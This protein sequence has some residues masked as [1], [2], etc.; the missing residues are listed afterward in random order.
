MHGGHS[1]HI[2]TVVTLSQWSH[3]H[4]GHIVTVVTLSQ[5]S[6]CHSGNIVTAV[7]LSQWSH[8]HS[9]NIVTVVTLSQWSHCHSGNI[10]TVVTLSH[11][12]SGPTGVHVFPLLRYETSPA[13]HHEHY[14]HLYFTSVLQNM[15][16]ITTYCTTV[17]SRVERE[18]RGEQI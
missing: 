16:F 6:H 17:Q 14:D 1:G 12:H 15:I 13:A 3:C 5:W 4:S 9:G 10:V 8:C 11:C 7:T 18:V 2:V